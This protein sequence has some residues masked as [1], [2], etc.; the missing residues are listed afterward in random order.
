MKTIMFDLD[1]TLLDSM[2][3]WKNLG[4]N[5][6][7]HK[8]FKITDDVIKS[9]STMSLVMSSSFLKDYYKLND[10]VEE[11]HN[12]F[13]KTVMFSY[14]NEVNPKPFAIEVLK[15]Y[16]SA[17]E[18]VILTTATNEEFVEPVLTKLGIYNLF[19]NIYTSDTVG[20]MKDSPDFFIKVM[21]KENTKPEDCIL[22]DDSEFALL[23]AKKAG[24][25]TCCVID[26]HSIAN[27]EMLKKECNF[28]INSFSEWTI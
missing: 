19:H 21:Q 28:F 23:A 5:F 10:T 14:L 15:K 2:S 25:S 7:L 16:Y 18:N 12:D 11:I 3:M 26:E 9:M 27:Y 24:I 13:K 20:E 17:G 6:L 4:R 22:F 8:N 1:G